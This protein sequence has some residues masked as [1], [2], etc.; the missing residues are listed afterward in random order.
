MSKGS[1]IGCGNIVGGFF[2]IAVAA[3]IW[4]YATSPAAKSPPSAA[5]LATPVPTPTVRP[6]IPGAASFI[7]FRTHI[8][9]VSGDLGATGGRIAA[10]L[11]AHKTKAAKAEGTH[12]RRLAAT[13]LA[14]LQANPPAECYG[15]LYN[16]WE[17]SIVS[18]QSA[19]RDLAAGRIAAFTNEAKDSADGANA[20][21][22][23][24][25]WTATACGVGP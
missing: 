3:G 11:K 4:G 19:G 15:L 12:L 24:L 7:A 6:P 22:G 9:G 23:D 14:W 8:G 13:E 18:A 20:V 5:P 17:L 10:D 2:L 16:E 1:G 25:G 21:S